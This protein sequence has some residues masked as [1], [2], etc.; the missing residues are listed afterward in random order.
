MFSSPFLLDKLCFPLQHSTN[1]HD[2][3][4]SF[5]HIRNNSVQ[6][7]KFCVCLCRLS[8]F[9]LLRLYV[10]K[11]K[12]LRV[13]FGSEIHFVVYIIN[14]ALLRLCTR[15]QYGLF[16]YKLQ[17][18]TPGIKTPNHQI[19]IIFSTCKLIHEHIIQ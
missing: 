19:L 1:S 8:H 6:V 7:R 11:P 16:I 5:N 12:I 13:I 15:T 10:K 2:Q 14:M 4:E 3:T 9:L 18:L 17:V